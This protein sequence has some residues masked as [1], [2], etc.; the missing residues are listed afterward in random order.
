MRSTDCYG[1]GPL[2]ILQRDNPWLK[3]GVLQ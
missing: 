3:V 1:E 2:V